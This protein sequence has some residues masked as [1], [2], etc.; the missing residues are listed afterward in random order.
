M[1]RQ[2]VTSKHEA[3]TICARESTSHPPQI[4]TITLARESKI[5]LLPFTRRS[6]QWISQRAKVGESSVTP[7]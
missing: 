4:A 5:G 2:I 3:V 1:W 6:P 7:H